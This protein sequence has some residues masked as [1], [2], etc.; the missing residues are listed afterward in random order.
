[1]SR[2][3]NWL[4][5]VTVGVEHALRACV[6]GSTHS[7]VPTPGGELPDRLAAPG[8]DEKDRH[9]AAGL[10][11]VN[12]TGEVCA[13]GL[14]EGQAATARL[15]DIRVSMQAA[16]AEERDHLA[17]CES[18]LRDLY[19][20]PSVLN[21]LFYSASFTLGALA[22]MVGDRLSLGFVAATEDQV[23]HHLRS[24]LDSLPLDDERSRA[25]VIQ[26]LADEERHAQHAREAGGR[27]FPL[28]V[29]RAMS[30]LSKVMTYSTYRW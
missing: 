28:P 27:E 25:I 8:A 7:R 19:S 3:L 23:S 15:D 21:P 20:R 10:M 9:H 16:A 18:R 22:G 2:H 6:P 1:M 13:Q 26:M 11:R 12:H 5:H 30:A 29:K 24:H 4:D 14:Y 17:W